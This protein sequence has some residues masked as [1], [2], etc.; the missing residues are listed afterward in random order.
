MLTELAVRNLGVITELDLVVGPGLTVVTGET[1][2]GKTLIVDAIGLLAGGRADTTMVREGATEAVVEGRFVDGDDEFVARRVVPVDGRSRAYLDDR[3]ATVTTLGERVRDH[4]DLHAQHAQQSLLHTAGQ[5][6]ALD[7]YAGVDTGPLDRARAHLAALRAELAE[8]GGDAASRER[9]MDLLSFQLAELA[10]AAITDADE[11]V[12]LSAE[13]AVL[14]D[15]AAHRERAAE[16]LERLA[17]VHGASDALGEAIGS[18]GAA[19]AFDEQLRR[20][21]GIAAELDDAVSELRERAEQI[22]EDPER[23]A[24]IARRRQLIATLR[25]RHGDGTVAGLID[26]HGRLAERLG[27]LEDAEER[28][29]V[30]GVAIEDAVAAVDAAADVVGAARRSAADGFADRVRDE[31]RRL[32]MPAARFE[33]HVP[34]PDPGDAVQMLFSANPGSPPMPL[35]RIASGG[36]LARAMLS[37]R[38]LAAADQGTVVF[39]EVDAG[40]GGSAAIA[41]GDALARLGIGRQVLVVTHLAQVAAAADHQ[42]GVVKTVAGGTTSTSAVRL[43]ADDRVVELSR[44]LSGSPSSESARVHARELLAARGGHGG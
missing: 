3:M 14:A 8:L 7:R 9:E 2:A 41:V 22:V 21:E 37:L 29:A 43:T 24:E 31:L 25:R 27:M 34:D 16:A 38:L 5:R 17:G 35:A 39:D 42:I 12:R 13:E 20:L 26:E 15:V 36:E 18:L 23:L 44:M 19:D 10:E 1:G 30:L 6:D 28:A 4:V 33:V 11:D 32:A 40:I